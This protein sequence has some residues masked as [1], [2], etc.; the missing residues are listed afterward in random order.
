[1]LHFYYGLLDLDRWS[2]FFRTDNKH[3]VFL[4][5]FSLPGDIY[6]AHLLKEMYSQKNK[7][8]K[9]AIALNPVKVEPCGSIA[10]ALCYTQHLQTLM[11]RKCWRKLRPTV[12]SI[13][14]S[15]FCSTTGT[16]QFIGATTQF[17]PECISG[18]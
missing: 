14:I 4:F 17:Q 5:L 18:Y 9:K 15:C 2:T 13:S 11:E 12:G 6:E 7:Q 8:K 1:M 16:V 10:P 3:D